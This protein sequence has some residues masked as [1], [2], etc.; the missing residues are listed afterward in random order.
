MV[1][2][3]K[4]LNKMED[5]LKEIEEDIQYL[6]HAL[7]S[8]EDDDS[9]SSV[10][11]L[12]ALGSS[13]ELRFDLLGTLEDLQEA[14]EFRSKALALTPEDDQEL[15]YLLAAQGVS[16]TKRFESQETEES[17]HFD[18]A[19]KYGCISI[20]LIPN[21]HSKSLLDVV[22]LGSKY[23]YMLR[24]RGE[25]EDL[26]VAIE[27][28]RHALDLAPDD[29]EIEAKWLSNI[30]IT[31]KDLYRRLGGIEDLEKSIECET[32]ALALTPDIDPNLF[33]RLANLGISHSCRY[34]RLG[35]L[36]DL[37][38]AKEY[39]SK[40]L[41][42]A[43]DDHP[44]YPITL[45]NLGL[46]HK[47]LF[48]CQGRLENLD[49]AIKLQTQALGIIPDGHP[50]IPLQHYAL[51][52]T[53]LLRNPGPFN[54]SDYRLAARALAQAPRARF[55]HTLRLVRMV[56][57]DNAEDRL[58]AYQAIV[59][60]LPQFAGFG[61]TTYRRHDDLATLGALA[62]EAAS[63]A[64]GYSKYALALE[65]LEQARCV[66]WNQNFVLRAPI[67]ELKSTYPD[68]ASKLQDISSRL[69]AADFQESES[70]TGASVLDMPH[71]QISQEHRRLGIEYNKLVTQIRMLPGFSDFLRPTKVQELVRA[72]RYGPIVVLNC[73]KDQSDALLVLP[74]EST[75]KHVPLPGFTEDKARQ[76]RCE[77]EKS[78][79]S[80]ERGRQP[81]KRRPIVPEGEEDFEWVLTTLWYDIVRPIL[82]FLGYMQSD[83]SQGNIPHITWCPTGILSSLPFHA[84]GDYNRNR[85]KVFDYVVSSYTPTVTS[86]LA[87]NPKSLGSDSGVLAIGQGDTPGHSPL[88]GTIEE[89]ASIKAH[90]QGKVKYSQFVGDQATTGAVLDAMEQHDWVH[91]AC[92]AHQNIRDPLW[93]GFF[94]HDGTLDLSS[95]NKRLFK[96]KGLA[97]L[98]A[99]Q[100]ATGDE[101][102]PDEAV[103]L[104][105]GLLMAG[106]SSVIATLW[107]IVDDDAP[108]VA[109]RV[110]NELMEGGTLGNGKAGKALHSAVA[111]LRTEVGEREFGRWVPYIHLG[112]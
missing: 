51:L 66:V 50:N 82:Q 75:I 40:A 97:F 17:E 38:N 52:N 33:L 106:Y 6:L 80:K 98:S 20:L 28:Q 108:F 31:Y 74:G 61:L 26:K 100:T 27:Y 95:I 14:I 109:D 53:F 13:H 78:L 57:D 58:E 88:P 15:S 29:H 77:M 4:S 24:D 46:V 48:E 85:E 69:H 71:D 23:R 19:I 37:E 107:S 54:Y 11:L 84:A 105:S 70:Q 39:Y 94:L 45:A 36:A 63:V 55:R 86:L 96:N 42:L 47:S 7:T 73:H 103:H 111:A 67:D 44:H 16:L 22:N 102:V 112:L 9:D 91:L 10:S 41:T 92:H 30:G 59:D 104:A 62:S 56:P 21:S 12:A 3:R 110:Y 101:E 32:R 49:E 35:N 76:T 2:G 72:A 64:I 90:T 93:S 65:W 68:V 34:V 1:K 99:C 60:L 81:I 89:L 43:R 25:P 83:L 5:S 18:H 8:I 79:R 87:Y